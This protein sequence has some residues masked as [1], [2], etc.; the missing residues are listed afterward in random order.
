MTGEEERELAWRRQL[1]EILELTA[2][3]IHW[4]TAVRTAVLQ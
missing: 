2:N 4:E 1:A 3:Q